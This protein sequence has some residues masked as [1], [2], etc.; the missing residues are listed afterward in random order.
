MPRTF[1]NPFHPL[2]TARLQSQSNAAA[3][4]LLSQRVFLI[5][6]GKKQ[7]QIEQEPTRVT[8]LPETHQYIGMLC[9]AF[10]VTP[11][12]LRQARSASKPPQAESIVHLSCCILILLH[13]PFLLL[14]CPFAHVHSAHFVQELSSHSA[15]LCSR[16]SQSAWSCPTPGTGPVSPPLHDGSPAL[17]HRWAVQLAAGHWNGRP[18]EVMGLLSMEMWHSGTRLVGMVG[19]VGVG[20]GDLR[21]LFQPQ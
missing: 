4:V 8:S 7:Q 10:A 16:I 3:A 2:L 15:L 19:W 9:C 5:A 14:H 20:L 18:R 21:D 12:E 11:V 6:E 1:Q 13:H 17:T